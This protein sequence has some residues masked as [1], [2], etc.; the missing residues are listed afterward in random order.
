M[1]VAKSKVMR[2]DRDGIIGEINIMMDGLVLEEVGVF[3]YL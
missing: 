1:N 3:K 2:S